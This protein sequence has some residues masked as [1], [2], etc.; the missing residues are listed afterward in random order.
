MLWPNY[1][2]YIRGVKLITEY[3][4]VLT[5]GE[6]QRQWLLQGVESNR[7]KISKNFQKKEINNNISDY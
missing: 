6:E 3:A 7:K 5:K 2:I 4:A 1:I